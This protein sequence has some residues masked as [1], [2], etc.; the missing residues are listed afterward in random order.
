MNTNFITNEA[1]KWLRSKDVRGML[2]ISDSTL[3]T[4]RING[5]IPAYRLGPS[6]FYRYDEII[7]A[8]EANRTPKSLDS[9]E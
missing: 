3:Q 2:S 9:N 5:T 7:A 1:I 6:W 4:M 8:L